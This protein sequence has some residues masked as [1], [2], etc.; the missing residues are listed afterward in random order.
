MH[1]RVVM[2][3]LMAIENK[4]NMMWKCFQKMLR[5][6]KKEFH[7]YTYIYIYIHER[8]HKHPSIQ[9]RRTLCCPGLSTLC[10]PARFYPA[11]RKNSIQLFSLVAPCA[12]VQAWPIPV[13]KYKR[14]IQYFLRAAMQPRR[15]LCCPAWSYRTCFFCAFALS[16]ATVVSILWFLVCLPCLV[17]SSCPDFCFFARWPCLVPPS[18]PYFGF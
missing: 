9:P 12:A 8:H 14:R 16:C 2:L 5:N 18:C 3:G 1:K 10:S 15:T 6:N 13:P 7:M 11:Q 17:L 4:K